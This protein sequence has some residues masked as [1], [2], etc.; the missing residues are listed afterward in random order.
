MENCNLC[1][2]Q[3]EELLKLSNDFIGEIEVLMID[4]NTYFEKWIDAEKRCLQL[5][6]LLI[7][8]YRKIDEN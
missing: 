7:E 2:K 8:Q 5:K 3:I 4:I 1:K 6:K